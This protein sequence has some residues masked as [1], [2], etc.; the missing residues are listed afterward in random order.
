MNKIEIISSMKF[1]QYNNVIYY[2]IIYLKSH[3]REL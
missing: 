1:D 2:I 3:S